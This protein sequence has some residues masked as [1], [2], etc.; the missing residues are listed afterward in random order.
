MGW[1]STSRTCR[2][3]PG[4]A[5][6][7]PLYRRLGGPQGQFGRVRKISPPTEIRSPDLP[8]RSESLYRLSYPGPL[9]FPV[10][11]RS[12]SLLRTVLTGSQAHHI[13][14][15]NGYRLC[16]PLL[17][18]PGRK[19]DRSNSFNAKIKND[20]VY[21]STP[22]TCLHDVHEDKFTL[23]LYKGFLGFGYSERNQPTKL[24]RAESFLR[25]Q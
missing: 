3:T 18:Q 7:Y 24:H 20:W 14:C 6:R 25:S 15:L 2:F 11:T 5:T 13:S 23:H 12:F 21:T 22:I 10:G 4:K 16:F 17:R 9:W 8:A 1:V 19:T